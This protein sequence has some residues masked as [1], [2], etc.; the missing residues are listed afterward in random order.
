MRS[1]VRPKE[2][3]ELSI[4]VVR[5]RIIWAQAALIEGMAL[6]HLEFMQRGSHAGEGPYQYCVK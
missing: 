4:E 1:A 5:G 6:D 2:A 3:G